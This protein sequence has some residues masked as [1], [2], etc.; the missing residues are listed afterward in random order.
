MPFGPRRR[1]RLL[2]M[3]NPAGWDGF[4]DPNVTAETDDMTGDQDRR[5]VG[6]EV[7]TPGDS[8]DG[9]VA[10]SPGVADSSGAG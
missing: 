4:N 2:D 6:G 3:N 8:G 9:R 7:Q 5:G 1:E 10:G